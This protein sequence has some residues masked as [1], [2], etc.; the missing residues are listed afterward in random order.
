MESLIAGLIRT[1]E[2]YVLLLTGTAKTPY[3]VM[4]IGSDEVNKHRT[5][6]EVVEAF[7]EYMRR[8][9]S[10]IKTL[11]YENNGGVLLSIQVNQSMIIRH[12]GHDI[13]KVDGPVV[14]APVHL[15]N[16]YDFFLVDNAMYGH[17]KFNILGKYRVDDND[18]TA[19]NS[20]DFLPVAQTRMETQ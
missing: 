10:A 7:Q 18:V 6:P 11:T 19:Y 8:M 14:V 2:N 1:F 20:E 17:V 16:G 5:Q 13:L 3:S 9:Q 12:N 4:R 15:G